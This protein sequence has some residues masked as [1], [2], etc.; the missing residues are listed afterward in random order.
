[1]KREL[2]PRQTKAIEKLRQSL[3]SGNRR[4]LLQAPTGFG[5]TR[6]VAAVI[7][8]ALAKT[9]RVIVAVPSSVRLP[10]AEMPSVF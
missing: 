6:L 1:M 4:P 8:G 9:K 5:K 7:K 10:C 2:R 3:G